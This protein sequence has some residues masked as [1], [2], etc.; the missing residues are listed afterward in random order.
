MEWE[1]G[2]VKFSFAGIYNDFWVQLVEFYGPFCDRMLIQ[3]GAQLTSKDWIGLYRNPEDIMPEWVVSDGNFKEFNLGPMQ[4]SAGFM[5]TFPKSTVGSQYFT[6]K[7]VELNARN[8]APP[9]AFSRWMSRVRVDRLTR[10]SAQ[11]QFTLLFGKF[12]QLFFDPTP[13]W[14]FEN[15]PFLTYSAKLARKWVT[16]QETLKKSIPDKWQNEIP[17]STSLR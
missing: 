10:G 16:T 8:A 6:L 17:P 14:W 12:D 4:F 7:V 5:G 15:A 2:E 13:W 3:H 9:V 1:E 11:I